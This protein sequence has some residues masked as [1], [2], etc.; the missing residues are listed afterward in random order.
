MITWFCVQLICEFARFVHPLYGVNIIF[1]EVLKA[2]QQKDLQLLQDVDARWSSTLLMIDHAI[3]LREVIFTILV[4]VLLVIS[5]IGDRQV[6]C[7]QDMPEPSDRRCFVSL[8]WKG[9]KW[10][11]II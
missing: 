11:L 3:L 2:L 6:Q 4:R 9:A 10:N 8:V 7:T 5:I 1:S